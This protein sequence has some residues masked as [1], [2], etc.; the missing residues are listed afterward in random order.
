MASLDFNKKLCYNIYIRQKEEKIMN[1][2]ML[3]LG[4]C[5]AAILILWLHWHNYL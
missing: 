4:L 1:W 2:I 5:A 3:G